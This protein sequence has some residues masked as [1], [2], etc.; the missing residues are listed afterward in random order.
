MTIDLFEHNRIAYEKVEKMLAEQGKAAVIHPTGTGKSY[1]A[2]ALVAAHSEAHFL[3]LAPSEYIYKLQTRKLWEKE[4]I[5]FDNVVFH[6]YAWLMM[7]QDGLCGDMVADREIPVGD[8]KGFFAD[9]QNDVFGEVCST[10]NIPDEQKAVI[11]PPDYIIID[12]L[13]RTGAKKWGAAVRKLI[14]TYPE[15]KL[16][17][18]T[19]TNVRYLDRQRDMAE[20]LFDGCVASE[21]SLCEAMA[22]GIIRVPKYVVSVYADE[23]RLKEYENK[24]HGNMSKERTAVTKTLIEKLRR[25]LEQADKVDVVFA[26]HIP[27]RD[28]K[29][30]VFC[31]GVDHMFEMISKAPEWF[32]RIDSMP[33]V[34]HVC[35]MNPESEADFQH[36]VADESKHLRVLYCIDMLNEGIHVD[37]VDSVVLCRPTMSPIIYKQQIGRVMSAMG[38]NDSTVIFDLVNNF[39]SL[40]KINGLKEE[41]EQL[42]SMYAASADEDY[43]DYTGFAIIDELRDCRELMESIRT[44]LNPTWENFYDELCHYYCEHGTIEIDTHQV[45]PNGM[46]LG[47]WVY[48]QKALYRKGQLQESRRNLLEEL[49]IKWDYCHDQIF[50]KRIKQLLAYKEE[51]GDYN[52]PS[53]YKTEDGDRLGEWCI[54]IRIQYR[55]GSIPEDRLKVLNDIGYDWEN[56]D[57]FWGEGISHATQYYNEYGNLDMRQNY[58][59]GDGYRL[60]AWLAV[61]RRIVAGLTTGRMNE[62]RKARL[63]ALGMKWDYRPGS[64]H[65]D[66]Y[67]AAY[68]RY[69]EEHDGDIMVPSAYIEEDTGLK[70]G[71]WALRMKKCYFM[72]TLPE[73]K[74]NRLKESGFEFHQYTRFWYELYKKAKE[75]SEANG[76]LQIKVKYSRE[77]GSDLNHWV[78]KQRMEYRKEHHG[79]LS[80]EQVRLLEEIDIDQDNYQEAKFHNKVQCLKEYYD[81]YGNYDIT[82]KYETEDGVRLGDWL[83]KQKMKY[84]D[85]KMPEWQI[86]ELVEIGCFDMRTK[87]DLARTKNYS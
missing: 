9:A 78:V 76:N 44:S 25:A 21:M 58:I 49:G 60:G 52:V 81:R 61:Q 57:V 17:G 24:I 54:S 86:E 48:C 85:G 19:A 38:H 50:E 56:Y 3:W 27:R 67:L 34:Y 82:R 22:K 14:T 31:S 68:I 7:N 40:Y 51:H 32:G 66:E 35:T 15:A 74:A 63:D 8:S 29:I 28:A 79:K 83:V 1:I 30:I 46:H 18:L 87:R 39:D 11:D 20:E 72:G 26:K 37:G 45:E 77:N 53:K 4:H 71:A 41:Y 84:R 73:W 55:E 69:R 23:E 36:F 75:Y 5:R 65:F 59:C 12:E 43:T 42:R 16:V 47:L 70:L 33:R 13:H 62:T 10:K 2:F 64:D 6:T 80:E